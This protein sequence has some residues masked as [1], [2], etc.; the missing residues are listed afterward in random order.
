MESGG[1]L[2]IP[3]IED[4]IVQ[5]ALRMLL[6]AIFEPDF[7]D[8]SHG[9]RKHRSTHTA[10][11]DVAVAYPRTTWIIEGDIVGCF[12]NISHEKL[13]CAVS[14]R[15][16]DEK[17]LSLIRKFLRAG[18]MED[19][20][21]HQTY[22]GTPQGGIV[23]PLLC[24]IFLHELDELMVKTLNANR[25]Q[26]RKEAYE[27]KSKEYAGN[28][29]RI[30]YRRRKLRS[31]KRSERRALL[32]EIRELEKARQS[33]PCYSSRH[34][35]KLGYVRYAD[36][37]LILVNGTKEDAIA[38]KSKVKD[39][40]DSLG[41][42]L[43]EEKTKLTHWR[44]PVTFLGYNVQG[45]LRK[46]GVQIVAIF[47]IPQ[48]KVRRIREEIQKVCGYHHIPEADAMAR[49]SLVFR[50]WCNY[51]RFASAPQEDFSRL[52]YFAWWQYAHFLARKHQMSIAQ[53]I[54]RNKRSKRLRE[55]TV[56]GRRCQTFT[57]KVGGKERI[58]NIVPPKTGSIWKVPK[59]LTWD[60]DH[61]PK[62][63]SNWTKGRSLE[64]RLAAIGRAD[65]LCEGC[66]TKPVFQVH[67]PRPI[68]GRS[69]RASID[70]D[71][72][73][74]NPGLPSVA[75]AMLKLMDEHSA[76]NRS[77][78]GAPDARKRARPCGKG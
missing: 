66:G 25:T 19:W 31:A 15:I 45:R 65:G 13:V 36:D 44:K 57:M 38:I 64:T 37:F 34:P 67:H 28:R 6:E 46:K 30:S 63:M 35:T 10:L 76:S 77:R 4:R 40:L 29:N 1:L 41:L 16:A 32:G 62:P 71:K 26:T 73:Q 60:V 8:C 21:Y 18:Y 11:H 17:I 39:K 2:G 70:S 9:F 3:T 12:D 33:V 20:V 27:R 49:V 7:H 75:N 53:V 59:P 78:M 58:L 5:Q 74:R 69:F 72:A 47:T 42:E 50:G 51:Y 61:L 68:G 22:S 48:E 43:S 23:S 56:Q 24:N 52:S 54:K 14:R 55:I